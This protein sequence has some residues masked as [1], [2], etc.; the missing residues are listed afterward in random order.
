MLQHRPAHPLVTLW[1]DVAQL[2]DRRGAE[3]TRRH[4]FNELRFDLAHKV[5]VWIVLSSQGVDRPGSHSGGQIMPRIGEDRHAVGPDK[6]ACFVELHL[7]QGCG[8]FAREDRFTLLFPV[9]VLRHHLHIVADFLL[10]LRGDPARLDLFDIAFGQEKISLVVGGVDRRINPR[11]P[12]LSVVTVI[13]TGGNLQTLAVADILRAPIPGPFD[14]IIIEGIGLGGFG[15]R[16]GGLRPPLHRCR[17]LA[18]AE[19]FWVLNDSLSCLLRLFR[20]RRGRSGRTRNFRYRSVSLPGNTPN[21][22]IR[23]V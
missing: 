5:A 20:C 3:G 7:V 8:L 10:D 21:N 12:L 22:P 13:E 15:F 9:R 19:G 23:N 4:P 16:F 17:R 2:P 11:P 14:D 6:I 18:Q 1:G